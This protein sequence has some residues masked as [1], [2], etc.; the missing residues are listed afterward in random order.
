MQLPKD[1]KRPRKWHPVSLSGAPFLN[2]SEGQ[3]YVGDRDNGQASVLSGR[4]FSMV[5]LRLK[6]LGEAAISGL[7]KYC[8]NERLVH[9]FHVTPEKQS[10]NQVVEVLAQK[11]HGCLELVQ[12]ESPGFWDS[13]TNHTAQQ[14][15]K[16]PTFLHQMFPCHSLLVWQIS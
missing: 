2:P 8:R 6:R 10:W 5:L 9:Y 15:C 14:F 1:H 12:P 16:K 3:I 4:H 11:F 7:L 13:S